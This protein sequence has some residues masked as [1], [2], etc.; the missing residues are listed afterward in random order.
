MLIVM[1]DPRSPALQIVRWD[2]PSLPL[3][4]TRWGPRCIPLQ[5]LQTGPTL[6]VFPCVV[7]ARLI[8]CKRSEQRISKGGLANI[9]YL[10]RM[11][12]QGYI[13]KRNRLQMTFLDLLQAYLL[14]K[15]HFPCHVKKSDSSSV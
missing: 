1:W 15:G 5:M 3:Q 10:C 2:P 7:V 14:A 4:I 13:C 12:F 11:Q 8:A 6:K 9:E